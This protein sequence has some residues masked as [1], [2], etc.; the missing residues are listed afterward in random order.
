LEITQVRLVGCAK[1][2]PQVG[3]VG[4]VFLSLLNGLPEYLPELF[5]TN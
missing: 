3:K 5:A 1:E 2:K 4:S